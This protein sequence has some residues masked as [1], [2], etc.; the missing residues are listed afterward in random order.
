M[1]RCSKQVR[2]GA[3]ALYRLIHDSCFADVMSEQAKVLDSDYMLY[4][5]ASLRRLAAHT[6]G[7]RNKACAMGSLVQ[8]IATY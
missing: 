5:S 3:Q 4:H 7:Q 2:T 6:A 8:E 1:R